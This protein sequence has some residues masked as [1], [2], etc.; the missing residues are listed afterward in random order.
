MSHL[1]ES[2]RLYEECP[3]DV[4]IAAAAF[5][6]SQFSHSG[7]PVLICAWNEEKDLPVTLA[8]LA[9][10]TETVHP[11]V[12]DNG[13]TDRTT[14][15]AQRMGA[16]VLFEP[17][18]AKI[19]AL[20]TGLSYLGEELG[21]RQALLTD[22]D[23]IMSKHWARL[24]SGTIEEGQLSTATSTAGHHAGGEQERRRLLTGLR[25]SRNLALHTYRA[26]TSA[27]IRGRGHNMA[28]G[29]TPSEVQ[30]I[31]DELDPHRITTDDNDLV[32]AFRNH[33]A[34]EK[35]SLDPR[36]IVVTRGDRLS[37]KVTLRD[38]ISYRHRK[39]D[40]YHDWYERAGIDPDS[41]DIE[42]SLLQ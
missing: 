38:V 2:L 39:I 9:H 15:F 5:S 29:F 28:L 3:D 18:P 6:R 35:Y 33:G 26:A 37:G 20:R 27:P 14:E 31:S 12:V 8:T 30:T 13:S 17:K 24:M 40:R 4:V 22:A 34:M 1:R 19:H 36:T 10:S 16:T 42:L 21:A 11:I 23:T 32:A 25:F 41:A 7:I